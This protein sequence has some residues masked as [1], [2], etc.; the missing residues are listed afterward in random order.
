MFIYRVNR[1][2]KWDSVV[3]GDDVVMILTFQLHL[4]NH[5]THYGIPRININCFDDP[6]V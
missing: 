4:V 5:G 1:R 6:L 3:R 2:Y